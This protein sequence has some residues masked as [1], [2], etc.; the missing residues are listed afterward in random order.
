MVKENLYEYLGTNGIIRSAVHLE[1]IY[2]IKLV[3]LI[4]DEDKFL[5][6]DGKTLKTSVIVPQEEE[7]FWYEI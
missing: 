4:A 6:K 7:Q 1:G 2:S 3:R 5:T